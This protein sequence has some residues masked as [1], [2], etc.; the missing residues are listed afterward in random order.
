[1]GIDL[2]SGGRRKGHNVRKAPVT[3][4]VYVKLL[5]KLYRLV[6]FECNLFCSLDGNLPTDFVH[7]FYL[8]QLYKLFSA[9]IILFFEAE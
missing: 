6:I 9:I 7:L 8:A 3:K 5:E 1:M 4:N 2:K